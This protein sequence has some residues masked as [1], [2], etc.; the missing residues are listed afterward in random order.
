VPQREFDGII[1]MAINK[2]INAN[3]KNLLLL[4]RE[5]SRARDSPVRGAGKIGDTPD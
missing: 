4:P 3:P 2:S 5:G 1:K